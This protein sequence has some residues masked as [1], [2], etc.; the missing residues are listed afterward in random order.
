MKNVLDTP[1]SF[2]PKVHSSI[3]EK[4][5]NLY[6]FYR[7][8]DETLVNIQSEIRQTS[9]KLERAKLKSNHLP[10]ITPAGVWNNRTELHSYSGIAALDIDKDHN[11]HIKNF[12][13]LKDEI[14]KLNVVAYCGLSVSGQ[15]YLVL[16]PIYDPSNYKQHWY[17]L[18]QDFKNFGIKIDSAVKAP[19]NLRYFSHDCDAYFNTT[20]KT[21]TKR[22][23]PQPKKTTIT[24]RPE[25]HCF[26]S[27]HQRVQSC[28]DQIV[29]NRIDI[30]GDYNQWI[31]IGFC[32]ATAYGEVGRTL[33]HNVSQFH[34]DYRPAETDRQ[35]TNCIKAGYN[36][37]IDAFFAFC[38]D[39][40]ILYKPR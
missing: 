35:Y 40:G 33:Y 22:L 9:D 23:S 28:I 6:D 34:T 39:H 3:M 30:T 14:K 4:Q 21:Y 17:A 15:G 20:A 7:R 11:S 24:V 5:V 12:S 19:N 38:R 2:Y 27:N 18:E 8:A 32:L 13:A 26:T 25:V 29:S 36:N 1:V 31:T 10:V 37:T 16:V